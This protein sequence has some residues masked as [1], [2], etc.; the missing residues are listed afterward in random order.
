MYFIFIKPKMIHPIFKWLSTPDDTMLG[1]N[2][3]DLSTI[4]HKY[5]NNSLTFRI[6]KMDCL[7]IMSTN[8][9]LKLGFHLLI[10]FL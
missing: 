7:Q 8:D 6:V 4:F 1:L 9:L 10:S 3:A 2:G 5:K